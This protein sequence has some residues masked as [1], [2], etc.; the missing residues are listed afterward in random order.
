MI[1]SIIYIFLFFAG[2]NARD[3]KPFY[4]PGCSV[5]VLDVTSFEKITMHQ[6]TGK[7]IIVFFAPWCGESFITYL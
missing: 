2:I 3:V 4:P 7:Y 6:D 1:K 5:K